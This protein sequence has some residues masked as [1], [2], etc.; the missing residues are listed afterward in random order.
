MKNGS[1]GCYEAPS[2]NT[3]MKGLGINIK[4]VFKDYVQRI[5]AYDPR[6]AH[7]AYKTPSFSP[8]YCALRLS[9]AMISKYDLTCRFPPVSEDTR[10]CN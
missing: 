5:I 6:E 10:R 9:K 3:R 8:Q 2:H 1:I 7:N 4:T